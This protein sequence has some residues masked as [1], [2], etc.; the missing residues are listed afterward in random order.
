LGIPRGGVITADI[1]AWKLSSAFDIVIPRKLTDP[2]SKEQ[3]IGAILED[4]STYL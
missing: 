2:D 4:G 1:V 3:A